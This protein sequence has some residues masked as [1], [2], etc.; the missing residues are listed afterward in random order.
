VTSVDQKDAW[1][2]YLS[3]A[4]KNES[5]WLRDKSSQ[6]EMTFAFWP[7]IIVVLEDGLTSSFNQDL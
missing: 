3:R 5:K 7:T 2:N 6:Q 4:I 1:Q